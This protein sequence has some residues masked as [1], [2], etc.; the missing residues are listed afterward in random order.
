MVEISIIIPSYNEEKNILILHKEITKTLSKLK[1]SYE[2]IFI[3]DGS[4][5]KSEEILNNIKD[6]NTKVIHFRK[7][8]GQTAAIDAG[9]KASKGKVIITMDGDLQ[10]DPKDIPKLLNSI[11][12]GYD[13][14]AGW[15]EKRKDSFKIRSISK[16]AKILRKILL[17]DKLQDSGCTMRAYKKEC[18]KDLNL[19]G[20]MHRFI[21]VILRAKGFKIAQIKVNHRKRKF[22]K[23]KYNATRGLK[24]LLD[25]IL[26]KFW[27][28]FSTRPI[29]LFGGAGLVSGAIGFL[30]LL[31]LA[32]I[33]IIERVPIG[34]RPLLALSILLIII[35]IQFVIFGL[36]A[37]IL[38]KI[39]Y[40]DNET[41][42]IK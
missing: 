33:R 18:I 39:Y 29:H 23:T 21:H 27:M 9:F 32:Y 35:G 17:N 37:D 11:E 24:G 14:I 12:K 36:I 5:D 34:D 8:F 1:K 40:K 4:T 16:V 25:M 13:I 10:N 6:N 31:Y 41:Y 30:I 2:I 28:Q 7:N 42:R 20:E 15:R 22:G 19:Y 38:T 26:L 3:N